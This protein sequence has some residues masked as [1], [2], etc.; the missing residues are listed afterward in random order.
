MGL[1]ATGVIDAAAHPTAAGVPGCRD[2][3]PGCRDEVRAG[4]AEGT[5]QRKLSNGY[6]AANAQLIYPSIAG[7]LA[8][9]SAGWPSRSPGPTTTRPLGLHQVQRP[10]TAPSAPSTSPRQG[11]T[12]LDDFTCYPGSGNGPTCRLRRLLGQPVLPRPHLHGSRAHPQPH[13]R[14][15]RRGHQL[16]QQGVLSPRPSIA[17]LG[18]VITDH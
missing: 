8:T 5:Q 12:P 11:T 4:D 16:G 13:R 17:E 3:M 10:S 6:V 18:L 14:G 1:P 9:A 15:R 7:Q 2:G